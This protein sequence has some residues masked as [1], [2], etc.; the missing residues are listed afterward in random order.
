[1]AIEH[2]LDDR[3]HPGREPDHRLIIRDGAVPADFRQRRG[4]SDRPALEQQI[5]C[6]FLDEHGRAV[7]AVGP[8]VDGKEN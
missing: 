1:L 4:V 8:R 2:L 7:V 3:A 5:A 6:A